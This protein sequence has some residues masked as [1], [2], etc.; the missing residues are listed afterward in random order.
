MRCL[1]IVTPV[2]VVCAKDNYSYNVHIYPRQI[3]DVLA[4]HYQ[5]FAVHCH[6][7][8]SHW[9]P[10]ITMLAVDLLLISMSIDPCFV[11]YITTPFCM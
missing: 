1:L 2:I 4:P 11:A 8:L 3:A 7:F 6:V 10:F 9:S 5:I